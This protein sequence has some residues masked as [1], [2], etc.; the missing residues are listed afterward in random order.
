MAT[1][2]RNDGIIGKTGKGLHSHC[3]ITFKIWFSEGV[4][5]GTWP[6]TWPEKRERQ[7]RAAKQEPVTPSHQPPM[8]ELACGVTGADRKTLVA[9]IATAT[10]EKAN[11]QG[12][13][14]Q[15]F[16][17]GEYVVSKFR[18]EL[19]KCIIVQ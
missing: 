6:E 5:P 17:I 8:M 18:L 2:E 14:S 4:L 16:K 13:P 19:K 15:A 7:H 9:L 3:N 12:M 10:G 1:K 11:Y